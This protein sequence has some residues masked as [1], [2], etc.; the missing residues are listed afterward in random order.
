MTNAPQRLWANTLIDTDAIALTVARS[1]AAIERSLAL[2]TSL[3]NN[4]GD[5]RYG[6]LSEGSRS[7]R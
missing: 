6:W 1:E 2:L 7:P 3:N 5:D 4:N